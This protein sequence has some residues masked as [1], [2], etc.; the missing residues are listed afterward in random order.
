M[1]NLLLD[2]TTGDLVETAG[3][4]KVVTG[5][6]AVAQKVYCALKLF[7]GEY[8]LNRSLGTPYYEVIFQKN[9]DLSLKDSVLKAQITNVPEVVELVSYKSTY[10]GAERKLAVTYSAKTSYGIITDQEIVL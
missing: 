2:Q 6:E 3:Q 9:V 8:W 10:I 7:L 4:L 1:N 5:L